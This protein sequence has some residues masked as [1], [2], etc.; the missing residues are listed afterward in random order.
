MPQGAGDSPGAYAVATL[1]ELRA[2]DEALVAGDGWARGYLDDVEA[3]G[4]PEAV[5]RAAA[6]YIVELQRATGVCVSGVECYSAEYDLA[7][8]PHRAAAEAAAG[9]PFRV[10]GVSVPMAAG[11]QWT[12]AA[13]GG[14]GA[15][16]VA[17]NAP[18]PLQPAGGL[19]PGGGEN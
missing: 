17:G 1:P 10:G 8:C 13:G 12:G 16:A 6:H 11:G 9:V 19:W 5:F 18:Q 2:F 4:A 3:F 14:D 7:S 15:S